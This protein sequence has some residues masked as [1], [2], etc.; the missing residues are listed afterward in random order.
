[1]NWFLID[2]P[3]GS[4]T[5]GAYH[6]LCRQFQ[7]AFIDAGA[8]E[9][10]ALFARR[11]PAASRQLYLSP[12]SSA[13]VPE[14]ISKYGGRPCDVPDPAAVTLV[15]GIPGAQ[16]LLHRSKTHSAL[17]KKRRDTAI[18]PLVSARKA[19]SAG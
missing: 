15:Y 12:M 14:L 2:M 17:P 3:H 16:T 18:Y 11:E 13:Y 1:M 4:L 5:D 10:L 6:R 7:R 9:E 8:P 19:A